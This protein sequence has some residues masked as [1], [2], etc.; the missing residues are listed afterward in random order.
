MNF[1]D[2]RATMKLPRRR[3][4]HVAA[5]AA[6]LPIVSLMARAE[7]YPSRPVR[8]VVG[9][10]PGGAGDIS[11]RLMGQWLSERLGQQ[12]II[13]NR[14]GAGTNIAT[15]A[16]VRA[17]ADGYTLLMSSAANAINATLYDRLNFNSSGTPGRS[18]ALCACRT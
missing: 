5:G 9:Y 6:A 4:L 16:V 17:G 8:I 1:G 12:F 3:F 18:R 7:T 15:E 14:T 2:G 13:E 10:A 11:M